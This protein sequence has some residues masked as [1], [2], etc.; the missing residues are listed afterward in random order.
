MKKEEKLVILSFILIILVAV[1]V[2]VWR[3]VVQNPDTNV[4]NTE[5]LTSEEQGQLVA[6]R[7][8]DDFILNKFILERVQLPDEKTALANENTAMWIKVG[9]VNEP[10]MT[11]YD[12]TYWFTHDYYG[13]SYYY[14]SIFENSA[15]ES[16]KDLIFLHCNTKENSPYKCLLNYSEDNWYLKYKKLKVIDKEL[17]TQKYKLF[18]VTY[19]EDSIGK[20][21]NVKSHKK[22]LEEMKQLRKASIVGC[23]KSK[24]SKKSKFIIINTLT[25]EDKHLLLCFYKK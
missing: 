18:S 8:V 19:L 7:S 1:S 22:V 10:V 6:L 13:N 24:F 5:T 20:F 12:E 9:D 23:G 14:G 11:G 21:K 25:T 3:I 2:F 15:I 17:K 4:E 16:S